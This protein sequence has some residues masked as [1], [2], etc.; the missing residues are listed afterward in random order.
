M[1]IKALFLCIFLSLGFIGCNHNLPESEN[2]GEVGSSKFEQIVDKYKPLVT[3]AIKAAADFAINRIENEQEQIEVAQWMF[4]VS[5][6]V[7]TLLAETPEETL[8]HQPEKLEKTIKLWIE[9]APE[10]AEFESFA[11][12]VAGLYAIEKAKIEEKLD[13]DAIAAFKLIEAIAAGTEQAAL[14]FLPEDFN[15][16]EENG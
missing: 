13:G 1:K 10:S 12:V 8:L 6:G 16:I 5:A 3:P 7:R 4:T 2:N 11:E 9:D 14:R 15:N